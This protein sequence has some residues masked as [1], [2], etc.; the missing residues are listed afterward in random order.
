MVNI[1]FSR[2]TCNCTYNF[3]T[4]QSSVHISLANSVFCMFCWQ[5]YKICTLS[6]ICADINEQQICTIWPLLL[7][8]TVVI[9]SNWL[10]IK[11]TNIPHCR[12]K[13]LWI[14]T[15]VMTPPKLR[16]PKRFKRITWGSPR[17]QF[18]SDSGLYKACMVTM[19]KGPAIFKKTFKGWLV[20][21]YVIVTQHPL[22]RNDN[23]DKSQPSICQ[24]KPPSVCDW[25]IW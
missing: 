25:S 5:I 23:P 1:F 16:P 8:I 14:G 3:K 12:L 10:G 11:Y 24:Q 21:P 2:N 7:K 17:D 6:L 4:E 15:H 22:Q 18:L 20:S 13:K 19:I 9:N